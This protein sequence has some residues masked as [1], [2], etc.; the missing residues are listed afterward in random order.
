[1]G[2][3]MGIAAGGLISQKIYAD[4]RGPRWYDNERSSRCF[5]HV[6]NSKDWETVTGGKLPMPETPVSAKSYT[7]AGLPWFALYDEHMQEVPSCS[8]LAAVKPVSW[9]EASEGNPVLEP[10]ERDILSTGTVDAGDW[11][12]DAKSEA[13]LAIALTEEEE[14]LIEATWA[15]LE[16]KQVISFDLQDVCR[17]VH[18]DVQDGAVAAGSQRRA[19][20]TPVC[21]GLPS[22]MNICKKSR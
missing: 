15:D 9:L 7:D 19:T 8:K 21:H 3:R 13:V 17:H 1:M 20:P 16:P 4:S 11:S 14:L 18:A 6:V 5:V 2:M 22:T 12:A 10:N